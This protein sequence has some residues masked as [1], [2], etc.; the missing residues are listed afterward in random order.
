MSRS[1]DGGGE[2]GM[3]RASDGEQAAG[4]SEGGRQGKRGKGGEAGE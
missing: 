2:D 1:A 3:A 4:S